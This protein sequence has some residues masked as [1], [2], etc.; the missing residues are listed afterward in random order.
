VSHCVLI[1]P[2]THNTDKQI[3]LTI[4][5]CR[6][7]YKMWRKNRKFTCSVRIISSLH[8]V[9]N[10]Y[11]GTWIACLRI[12]SVRIMFRK[13]SS[14]WTYINY[15][16]LWKTFDTMTRKELCRDC[17]GM[18]RHELNSSRAGVS[19]CSPPAPVNSS[20]LLIKIR[21]TGVWKNTYSYGVNWCELSDL[22]GWWRRVGP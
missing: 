9:S 18:W 3:R 11:Q 17:T 19:N 8:S 2:C 14:F 10:G 15:I 7:L 13:L 12:L 6:L 1:T 4:N 22:H 5:A 20:K 21:A 16:E